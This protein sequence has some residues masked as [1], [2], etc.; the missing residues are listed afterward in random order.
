LVALILLLLI[1]G[2][3]VY[4][5]GMKAGA[6]LS[7]VIPGV[8]EKVAVIRIDSSISSTQGGVLGA[9][10]SVDAYV[11]VIDEARRDPTVKAVVLVFNSPGGEAGAA[12]KLYY[13]VLKLAENK[14]VVAYADG[15]MASGA[16]EAALPARE[17]VASPSSLVG[18]VG[19]YSVVFNVHELLGKLGVRVYT[20]KSGPLKDVGSP[21]RNMTEA[22]ARVMQDMVDRLFEIFKN[23]VTKHRPRVSAE[24]FTGRPYVAGEA[25]KAGLI[26]KVG[27]LDDAIRDAKRLAGLPENAPVVEMRPPTPGLLDVLFGGAYSRGPMVVPSQAYLAMWPPPAAV[28]PP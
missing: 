8:G 17:I 20:F 18:A 4:L 23:R 28:L 11:K 25:L 13:A 26:D 10:Y 12:E 15:L 3:L 2:V 19:V 14:T 24:V 5:A 1:G 9:Q 7:P 6:G 22:D 21:F 27:T 16:Y